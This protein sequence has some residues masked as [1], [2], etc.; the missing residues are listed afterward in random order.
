M[1]CFLPSVCLTESIL[2]SRVGD[3]QKEVDED[4]RVHETV[5]DKLDRELRRQSAD[6][7]E[8][9]GEQEDAVKEVLQTQS[10]LSE[11]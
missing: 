3:I 9:L 1:V 4:L 8:L 5:K 11:M 2:E 7:E 10:G 6:Q